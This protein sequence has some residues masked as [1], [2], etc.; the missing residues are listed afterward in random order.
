MGLSALIAGGPFFAF[1]SVSFVSCD[2][3]QPTKSEF[4]IFSRYYSCSNARPDALMNRLKMEYE[5]SVG[6]CMTLSVL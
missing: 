4:L 6:I 2:S 1:R 5:N 3:V